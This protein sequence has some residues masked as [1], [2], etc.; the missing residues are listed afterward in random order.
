MSNSSKGQSEIT[1]QIKD[2]MNGVMNNM[3]GGQ[4]PENIS[5]SKLKGIAPNIKSIK[6]ALS[7]DTGVP[8]RYLAEFNPLNDLV[9]NIPIP[10]PKLK[11]IDFTPSEPKV[12]AEIDE[13]KLIE[14]GVPQKKIEELKRKRE[15]RQKANEVKS[16]ISNKLQSSITGKVNNIIGGVQNLAQ[17][18]LSGA[19]TQAIGGINSPIIQKIAAYKYFKAQLGTVDERMA[20]V[21]EQIDKIKEEAKEVLKKQTESIEQKD[22]IKKEEEKQ[23]TETKQVESTADTFKSKPRSGGS[24]PGSKHNSKTTRKAKELREKVEGFKANAEQTLKN[25]GKLLTDVLGSL[26]SLLSIILKVV[27]ALLSV[28]AFIMFLKQL[29]ELLM[30][31]LFKKSSNINNENSSAN[32][33]EDFLNEIGYPGLTNEDFSTLT[34]PLSPTLF[35]TTNTNFIEVDLFNPIM[36]GS[37]QIGNPLAPGDLDPLSGKDFNNHPLLG[38]LEGIHPQ[39]TN[40]LYNNGTLPLLGDEPLDVNQ[41]S[42]DLD[43]IYDDLLNEFVETQQIEYIEK[44]YNLDFEMIGYKRY[45]A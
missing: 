34:T 36:F 40:E 18:T 5:L 41:Y 4:I 26:G 44:L 42:E 14:E 12:E 7:P 43:Q 39:L 22:K 29:M 3:P 35:D 15:A 25:V 45:K 27:G 28:I 2:K 20:G 6:S 11:T 1:N 13:A 23:E 19:V 17:S 33:P 9:K 38:D 24:E 37:Y 31:L 8:E 21:K 16:E 30:L 10:T 32:S